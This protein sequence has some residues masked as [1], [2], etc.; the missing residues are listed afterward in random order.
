MI[1]RA[2]ALVAVITSGLLATAAAT[3]GAAAASSP[4]SLD[5]AFGNGGLEITPGAA[6]N[7]AL[8]QNGDILVNGNSGVVRFLPNGTPDASFGSNGV[9]SAAN[10]GSFGGTAFAASA[11]RQYPAGRAVSGRHPA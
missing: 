9:A 1:R 7:A 11:G 4:G 8:Q 10:L 6:F 2:S 5:S 3:A